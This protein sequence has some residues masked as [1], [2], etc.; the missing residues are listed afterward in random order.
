VGASLL[1]SSWEAPGVFKGKP[2]GSWDLVLAG[3]KAPADI[4]FD[5]KRSLVLVPRFQDNVV[6]V[7]TAP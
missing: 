3:I 7:Y 2:G 1:V 6:E 4:G 5:S